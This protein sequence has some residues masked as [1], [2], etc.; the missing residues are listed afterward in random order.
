MTNVKCTLV[1]L[2]MREKKDVAMCNY[3][4]SW[5]RASFFIYLLDLQESISRIHRT[6]ELMYSD[7]TMVQ[8]STTSA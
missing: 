6:I 8:V 7:K 5:K 3:A 1:W 4:A 2:L